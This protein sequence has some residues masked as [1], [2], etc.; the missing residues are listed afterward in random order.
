MVQKLEILFR[1]FPRNAIIIYKF[2][3]GAIESDREFSLSA[4]AFDLH[5]F[6][7]RRRFN[8]NL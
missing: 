3:R 6:Q 1:Q 5:F 2:S 4:A 7:T 8:L